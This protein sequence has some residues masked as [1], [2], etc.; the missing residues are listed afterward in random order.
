MN[1][2]GQEAAC[3]AF[4]RENLEG[5]IISALAKAA[6]IPLRNAMDLYYGSALSGQVE[7]G[8]HGIDN[9]SAQYLAA[10]LLENESGARQPVEGKR[11]TD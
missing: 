2:P 4:Y 5:D 3:L 8:K 9:L 6:G 10:D 11:S 1:E 7:T